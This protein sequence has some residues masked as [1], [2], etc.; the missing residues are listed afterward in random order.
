MADPRSYR[1]AQGEIPTTPGVYRFVDD[2]GKVIYVGKA[3]N[4]R[5]R[6]NSYFAHPAGLHP[7]TYAM[8]HTAAAVKWT[9]VNS[10]VEALQLEYT[11]I[12]EFAPR[13]NVMFRDNKSYPYL[14]VTM[15]EEF[16][17]ALITRG[18]RR[19]GV[20][21]FGPFT[22]VWAIRETLDLLLKAFPVRTCS[23][24][25]FRRAERSGRPCLLGY[26]DKCSAPCVG[27]ISEP[28]YR[29]LAQE[30]VDFMSG[31]TQSFIT[32]RKREMEEAS[33]SL[34]FERAA[35]LRDEVGA[36]TKV[37]E[38]SAVVL[39]MN[40]DADVFALADDDLEAAVQVFHVRGGRIRGERGWVVEKTD[41]SSPEE[42]T[43]GYLQ[44]VYGAAEPESIPREV[45]VNY[46]PDESDVL[47]EWLSERRGA[48][49]SIRVPR[50][51]EKRAVMETVEN[52]AAHELTLHKVRRASDVTTRSQALT[53][54]QSYL[55]LPEA[56]L[57]MECYDISH[58]QGSNV[59]ASMVVFEDGMPKKSEY[60]KF[61]ITGEAARDDTASMYDVI[62][63]RFSRYLQSQAE[64]GEV[65][66]GETGADDE[67]EGGTA[68]KFSYP[69]SLVVVDGAL[70]QVQAAHAALDD[71]GLPHISVVGL[72][73][74]L[75]EVWVAGEEFPVILPRNSDG[76][77][78]LQRLRDEAHRFAIR[79]HRT[80]RSSA[81]T[82]SALDGIPGL[83]PAKAKTLL[84]RLGSVKKISAADADDLQEVPGIGP[85]LAQSIYAHFHPDPT[86]EGD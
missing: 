16:P 44:Q 24:G 81:M 45:L 52:N 84:S 48:A 12:K 1:P 7:R 39:D 77:F 19:K 74:R 46:L 18:K 42:L 41:D 51:G 75:E 47:R 58:T 86:N 72:A 14:A 32:T 6:L 28:G 85:A 60:R 70:P 22:H 66:S 27:R 30:L 54:I 82:R 29:G 10:E 62:S 31:R 65:R 11:W 67:A 53:D 68:A 33:A 13:F 64:A 49:V 21:Y 25:V 61:S 35:R 80:K 73:K 15:N 3:K 76:L 40:T 79:F 83:G 59:V 34:D 38:K 5:S 43:V 4:L 2:H 63:R 23:Q 9:V 37:L 55:D 17:R 71:L 26:I 8:V 57:R 20:K 78:L 56:P 36:L 50:R 69:P